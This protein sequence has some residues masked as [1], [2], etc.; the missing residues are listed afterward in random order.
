M[1]SIRTF[2]P[3][4]LPVVFLLALLVGDSRPAVADDELQR[5]QSRRLVCYFHA[6]FKEDALSA[7][8]A[9]FECD[10]EHIDCVRRHIVGR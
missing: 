7:M 4:A 6:Q 2:L 9:F 8:V 1:K 5:C 3:G 10:N